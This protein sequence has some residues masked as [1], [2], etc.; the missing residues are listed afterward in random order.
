MSCS[1]WRG[2]LVLRVSLTDWL[3]TPACWSPCRMPRATRFI[4]P[5]GYKQRVRE[6]FAGR[7]QTYH[8]NPGFHSKVARKVLD[9]GAL[10]PG[11]VLLDAACGTGLITLAAAPIVGR[12]GRV[13]ALDL[14]DAMIEKA[15][16]GQLHMM[17]WRAFGMLSL[18]HC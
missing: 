10:K 8:D 9:A 7:A 3:S 5:E 12:S 13:V 6:L 1:S 16:N 4:E 2:I 17:R 15:R 14:S 18:E 11:N